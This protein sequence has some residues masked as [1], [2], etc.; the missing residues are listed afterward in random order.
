VEAL[1]NQ[2][3]F[4]TLFI[5]ILVASFA[6]QSLS[7]AESST[8]AEMVDH[9]ITESKRYPSPFQSTPVSHVVPSFNTI[10]YALSATK[11]DT[12][13]GPPN[14][15]TLSQQTRPL[16]KL[17]GYTVAPYLS[18]SLKHIGLGFSV[19]SGKREAVYKGNSQ[20][21]RQSSLDYR[22]VG[23]FLYWIPL[24]KMFRIAT[25]TLILGGRNYT[26][27]Q[28]HQATYRYQDGSDFLSKN[29]IRYSVPSYE[30]GLNIDIALLKS[31]SLIPWA[32]YAYLDTKDAESQANKKDSKDYLDTD[33][34]MFWKDR[35]G[36]RY[37]VDFA[38]RLGS[39]QMRLGGIFGAIATKG[40]TS[41]RIEDNSYSLTL[42]FEQSGN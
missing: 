33:I 10:S 25:P 21:E 36:L 8:R 29:D 39:F 13:I 40:I 22:G 35:P 17:T 20:D 9:Y 32:N 31:F 14:A 28:S 18:L 42:S 16:L 27:K 30:G 1:V 41:E 11:Q 24:G 4:S 37:G 23:V 34:Q 7:A 15:Q 6:T 38:A 5:T 19:E 3:I 2:R 12:T 26:A